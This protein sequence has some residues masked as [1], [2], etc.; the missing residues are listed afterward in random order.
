VNERSRRAS[1]VQ[2]GG[3]ATELVVPVL[4]RDVAKVLGSD[5]RAPRPCVD[6]R[7]SA[8]GEDPARGRDG[9]ERERGE[10]EQYQQQRERAA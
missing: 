5:A 4:G 8:A 1:I 3:E 9:S 2:N 7:Q 10:T 6:G